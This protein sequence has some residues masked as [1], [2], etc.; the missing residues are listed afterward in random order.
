MDKL[1]GNQPNGQP[2][3]Q[4]TPVPVGY[5]IQKVGPDAYTLTMF[6]PVG[7]HVTFWAGKGLRDLIGEARRAI[8][9]LTLPQGLKYPDEAEDE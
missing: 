5:S 3:M 1:N 6:T 4:P 7:I 2:P 9:G 8:S